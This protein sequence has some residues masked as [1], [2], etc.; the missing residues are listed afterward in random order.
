VTFSGAF[1]GPNYRTNVVLTDTSGR[2]TEAKLEARGH[3]GPI[4][5]ASLLFTA[6]IGG[7]QQLNGVNAALSLAPH[8]AGALLV[9][10]TRG[11]GIVTVVAIDNRTNDPTYFPPDL[12]APVV[13]TIPAIGH[14]DG[15]HD[16]KFRSDL[17]FVNPSASTRQMTLEAKKW[18]SNN[19]PVRMQFT[20]LPNEAR[21]VPD[22]L[23]TLF[24]MEGIAR[25]RYTSEGEGEGVRVT[26][27]AYNLA[28]DGGTF[29][30][31]V[32][33][34]NN[35]QSAAAG[36]ALEIIGITASSSM[37]ANLGLVELNQ[38]FNGH[39]ATARI[40][41]IDNNGQQLDTFTIKLPFAG[42]TQIN[43]LFTARGIT[44][45]PSAII[46]VE[47]IEGLIGAYVTMT[48]NVTN[49]STFVGAALAATE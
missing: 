27:R 15:A 29:G 38:N 40:R 35:F 26:S 46:R 21:V 48:D 22:A 19:A 44:P 17:Y 18:D 5:L 14:V 49:D 2:G 8:E 28:A 41:I 30:C 31:L 39:E 1:P 34:L 45:P 23:K 37:R 12:P 24:G 43:D 42:G 11:T 9:T 36:E 6:P 13:R 4:G 16:A 10:P 3:A 33:P 25:F 7:L 47:T 32:P 20:L